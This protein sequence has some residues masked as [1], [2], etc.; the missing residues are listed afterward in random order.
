MMTLHL[1][2]G[3]V[4]FLS[5]E[6][7]FGEEDSWKDCERNQI[8]VPFWFVS[9]SLFSIGMTVGLGKAYWLLSLVLETTGWGLWLATVVYMATFEVSSLISLIVFFYMFYYMLI[10]NSLRTNVGRLI[11]RVVFDDEYYLGNEP[12]ANKKSSD[13]Y[14]DEGPRERKSHSASSYVAERTLGISQIPLRELSHQNPQTTVAYGT[15]RGAFA[16]QIVVY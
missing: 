11:P 1:I 7:S 8:V 9:I 5:L 16:D 2:T 12:R 10:V 15:A 13:E 6:L 3:Y 4:A 14:Y